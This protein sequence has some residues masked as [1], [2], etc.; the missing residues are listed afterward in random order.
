MPTHPAQAEGLGGEALLAAGLAAARG[1]WRDLGDPIW[2]PLERPV[3][4]ARADLSQERGAVDA[5]V[6]IGFRADAR[7]DELVLRLLPAAAAL[8]DNALSVRVTRDGAPVEVRV[9]REGA[10]LL[11]PLTPA[12]AEGDATVVR[13]RLGYELTDRSDIVDDGG[14]AGFGLLARNPDAT[15]LGH[16]LPLLTADTGPMIPWGDV[17]AF[18][19]AVWTVVFTSDGDMV[20]GGAEDPCPRPSDR[21]VWLRGIALRDVSAVVYDAVAEVDADVEGFR[22]NAVGPRGTGL[23]L[24]TTLAI[25]TASVRSF[26]GRFGPLA[27]SELDVAAVA[28]SE[29]AAGMEFPGLIVIDTEVYRDLDGGFGR[30]VIAH[31]VGHQW[32]HALVGNGSLSSPVVDES[33]AQYLTYLHFADA[34]GDAAARDFAEQAFIGRYLRA[35]EDGLEDEPPAQPLEAFAGSDAYGALVYGRAAVAW[36]LAEQEVGR[37]VVVAFLADVVDRWGLELVSDEE[38]LAYAADRAPAIAA[39]LERVWLDPEPLPVG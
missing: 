20:S 3:Y 5:D 25:S 21:C 34:L 33:L 7:M 29:G 17:G 32:F 19:P 36:V 38:L 27:W 1:P 30:F 9:D 12:L 23:D 15:F 4:V 13:V 18:P 37:E 10:R 35:R 8:G 6:T 24:E 2:P 16:W 28:L 31:E 39:V 26:E 11:L 14:P 22:V